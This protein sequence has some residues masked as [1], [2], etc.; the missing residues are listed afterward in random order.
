MNIT[1]IYLG[2]R[3]EG[4]SPKHAWIFACAEYNL[5]HRLGFN[6]ELHALS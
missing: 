6:P 5:A 1:A 4:L 2:F 3:A